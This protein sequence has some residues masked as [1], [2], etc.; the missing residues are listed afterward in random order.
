MKDLKQSTV[1][2]IGLGL[3]GGSI[4]RALRSRGLCKQIHACGR[5]DKPLR[6]A[7]E[8]GVIDRWST[9]LSELSPE[10]DIVIVAVPTLTVRRIL[11]QIKPH[12]QEHAIITDAASV[13]GSV[14]KDFMECM[15]GRVAHF[16]PAHPIAGS[17]RSGYAAATD[18]L[19]VDRKLIITPV[20]GS[21]AQALKLITD[22][23]TAMG[24]QV[25]SMSVSCHDAVLAA[26]SHLPHLLAYSL[27]NTLLNQQQVDDVFRFAAGGFA[28]FTRIAGSDP[29][30]WRDIFLSNS[31]AT[32]AVLDEY[33]E[34]LQ[35]MRKAIIDKDGAL[36]QERFTQAQQARNDFAEKF[37]SAGNT[38]QADESIPVLTIDGPG[39]AGKGT[40]SARVAQE[41]GWHYL[42]SGALYRLLGLAANQ[43]NVSTADEK[44]LC[45]LIP[46]MSISF[47]PQEGEVWLNKQ[48][49]SAQLRTEQGG[50]LASEVAVHPGVRQALLT[51]QRDFRRAP[52]LVA[53]GRDMGTAVFPDAQAKVFLTASAEERAKRRYKQ[54]IA[55]GND[56]NLSA[57]F[58]DIKARDERDMNRSA[59]PLKPAADAIELDTTEISIDQV[60]ARVLEIVAQSVHRKIV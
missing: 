30:M 41:L 43:A 26:T 12:L 3:I 37:F 24:A 4:A 58:L 18:D 52:G 53:D 8:D 47:G 20:D 13:K 46:T 50:A 40:I 28:G 38:A 25:H 22:M 35:V 1:L 42:D 29:I 39:G 49:V 57:L 21:S 7:Q 44:A 19:Y 54:L 6:R 34:Q 23:W 51:L 33:M 17:E 5:D 16:V 9:D 60:L 10:A 48:E 11:E 2:I 32:V 59:S 45:E 15:P 27:V 56:V 36:L 55:K 31:E 14:V